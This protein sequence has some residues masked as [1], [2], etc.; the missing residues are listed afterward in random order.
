MIFKINEHTKTLEPV[1]VVSQSALPELI[2]EEYVISQSQLETSHWLLRR[3]IFGEELL[4]IGRQV[5]TTQ[6]KRADIL[7]IDQLGNSVIVELKR[8]G[9]QLGVETQALQYLAEFSAYKGEHFI[10]QYLPVYQSFLGKQASLADDIQQFTGIKN[11][12]EIN[13]NSRIILVAQS[14]DRVLFSMGKWLASN[15]VAFRCIEYTYLEIDS[16]K[17]LSFSV[18]FD[19]SPSHIYPLSFPA[20]F[21]ESQYFWHNIGSISG[22]ETDMTNQAWWEYLVKKSQIAASFTNQRGGPGE[23]LLQEYVQGDRVLAYS[24]GHGAVGYGIIETPNKHILAET[25]SEDDVLKGRMRHRL[26]IKWLAIIPNL[27]DAVKA[28]EIKRI[29]GYPPIPTKVRIKDSAIGRE[30]E[31]RYD[32]IKP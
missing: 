23:L 9:G 15:N 6:G 11:L 29:G 1:E 21:R 31:K 4:P 5:K 16:N 2:L 14:F 8:D 22:S 26:P 27:R 18:A 20:L 10:D 28:Q 12:E 32:P 3:E 25:D 24:S 17:F 13:Q 7:A 30:L 19:D